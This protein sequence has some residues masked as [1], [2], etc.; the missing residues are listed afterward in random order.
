MMH[1]HEDTV[2]GFDMFGACVFRDPQCLVMRFHALAE[3]G[4]GEE[5]D[6]DFM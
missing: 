6:A 2:S 1:L 4:F 5:R 3:V